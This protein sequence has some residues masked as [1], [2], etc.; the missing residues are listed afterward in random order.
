MQ[1]ALELWGGHE[2]TL[3]RVGRR[4]RDQTRLSGHDQRPGDLDLFARL[5]LKALRYPL[6]W[7]RVAQDGD[8]AWAWSQE[9]VARLHELGV[10]PILGLVHHG[11]G[12]LH[13]GLLDEGFAA[14]LASHAA[15]AARRNP[16][17]QDW[18]PVNEPLTTARFSALYGLWHPHLHDEGALW[19]ALLNQ[20]D[21]TRLSMQAIRRINPQARLIQ[22][23]D[24]GFTQAVASLHSQA[25]F[26]NA[27]RWL[28]WDLLFGRVTPEHPLW[29]RMARC[30]LA[31]RLA[32]IAESPCPPD[33]LGVNY[34]VTSERFLDSDLQAYPD[35]THG[36]NDQVRYADVEAVRVSREG[37]LG[38]EGVLRQVWERYGQTIAVTESHLGCAV[39]A[40]ISWVL[41]GWTACQTLRAQ[42]VEVEAFTVWSLLGAFDWD[43]LLTR[44][45]GRYEP[46]VFDLT[47]GEPGWTPLASVVAQLGA[48]GRSQQDAAPSPGW[49][50]RPERLLYRPQTA[51]NL[52]AISH[53]PRAV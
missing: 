47:Q 23:E 12:P 16:T 11:A 33:V 39:A 6:L 50:R 51:A 10:R 9:R 38:L 52:T 31:E 7:E 42:G 20:I 3:N 35:W 18:T 19:T 45:D 27:R 1:G 28:T 32:A 24:L 30:G 26:E 46:G 37:M 43:S 41:E 5:N 14:G 40:Q 48:R 2:C 29:L 22:T 25:D 15:E 21:A 4:R 34:Y 53:F 8:A 44:E 49:W 17:V 13:G 36:G